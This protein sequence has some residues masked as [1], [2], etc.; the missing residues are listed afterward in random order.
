M[1]NLTNAE[2]K[3]IFQVERDG[4]LP[5]RFDWRTVRNM[6]LKGLIHFSAK[7]GQYRIGKED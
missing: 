5:A 6:E 3:I 7:H 2:R 4:T 1:T